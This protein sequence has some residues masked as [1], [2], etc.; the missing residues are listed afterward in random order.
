[1]KYNNVELKYYKENT[2][3]IYD[4]IK[5]GIRGGLASVLG[6]CHVKCMNKQIDPEYTRKEIYLKNLD[7]NSLYASAMVQAL[8]T[9]EISKCNDIVYLQ[10]SST[11]SYIYTIDIKYN[12]D[13]K[14]KKR[15]IHSFR[16]RQKLTLISLQTIKM[17]TKRKDINPIRS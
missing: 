8:P 12:N 10:S 15:N 14:L 5:H 4:T 7:F 3:N 6:D 1:M 16:N 11:K 13:L 17:K 2:V 9:G